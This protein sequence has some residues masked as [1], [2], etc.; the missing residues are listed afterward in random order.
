MYPIYTKGRI[1]NAREP[2]FSGV[3]GL[4]KAPRL[5]A[6]LPRQAI[7]TRQELPYS[8][9]AQ[10]SALPRRSP[11]TWLRRGEEKTPG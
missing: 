2:L 9:A 1:R 11:R 6:R 7:P 4:S 8:F 10:V 5:G 3:Q